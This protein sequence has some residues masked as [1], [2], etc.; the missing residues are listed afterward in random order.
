LLAAGPSPAFLKPRILGETGPLSNDQTAAILPFLVTSD[1]ETVVGLHLS[2][3]N[4][5]PSVCVRTLAPAVG[6]GA[7]NDVFTEARTSDGLLSLCVAAQDRPMTV[8]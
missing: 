7:A 8:W 3:E 6:A 1:T 5:R 4:N 2:M